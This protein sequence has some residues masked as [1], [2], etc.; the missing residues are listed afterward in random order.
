MSKITKAVI[1]VRGNNEEFQ[2]TICRVYASDRGYK[3]AYV[4]RNIED[5]TNCDVLLVTNH[6]RI[7]RDKM[8]YHQVAKDF[9]EKGIKIESI[10]NQD[11]Y[12][13]VIDLAIYLL[14]DK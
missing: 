9:E 8:K 13:D 14:K 3:V 6:H 4:T 1:Y 5:V 10:V 7:S 2:E 12:M 11:N